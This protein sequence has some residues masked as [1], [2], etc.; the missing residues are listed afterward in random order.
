MN[1]EFGHRHVIR[2]AV[3]HILPDIIKCRSKPILAYACSPESL[4]IRIYKAT[5]LS[6]SE[7]TMASVTN[8]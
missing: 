7:M 5:S 6:S 2:Q 3:V 8:L 4:I 1:P